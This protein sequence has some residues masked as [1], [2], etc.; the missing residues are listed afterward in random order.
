MSFQ[1]R[2][3]RREPRTQEPSHISSTHHDLCRLPRD[4]AQSGSDRASSA[5]SPHA[6]PM[7]TLP[8]D[9]SP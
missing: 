9:D 2:A 1:V 8:K 5:A 6:S 3:K 4:A 7:L